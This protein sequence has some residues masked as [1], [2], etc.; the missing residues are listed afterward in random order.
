M[1]QTQISGTRIK[2]PSG[3]DAGLVDILSF[4]YGLSETDVQVLM[5]LMRGDA[6]GTEELESELKLSKAS[7]NRSLN[8]L[9]EMALV[10]RIKEPGNKAGRPRYLYKSKDYA[11]L[12]NKILDDI[13]DCA[14]KMADLVNQEFKP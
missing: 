10:M 14:A 1:E 5:A 4:C 3:K 2:L 8:K 9:L 13:K 7:I 11:E 6:R 12:K